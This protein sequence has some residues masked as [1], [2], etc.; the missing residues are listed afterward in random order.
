[1][2]SNIFIKWKFIMNNSII[3][4]EGIALERQ[5]LSPLRGLASVVIDTTGFSV[6]DL[7]R[8]VLSSF[9]RQ[10]ERAAQMSIRVV[11]FGFKYGAPQD[12]DLVF[13]VRFLK[14]PFFVEE[15]RPLSGQDPA[16]ASYVLG[17]PDAVG[18]FAVL[19]PLL[20]YCIPKFRAEGK[21]Y[22][23]IAVGCTG[24]RHRS[25]ALSERIAGQLKE[26]LGVSVEAVHRD[27][28]RA[29]HLSVKGT[30]SGPPPGAAPVPP[31]I[32]QESKNNS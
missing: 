30:P 19:M 28:R 3:V 29:E 18:F 12:A 13:D 20:Q 2:T 6:H 10:G 4:R 25:V 26:D 11:S 1:M 32:L 5:L 15:L 24:G 7:R 14:N 27:T 8:E 23:T 17:D 22:L 9:S 31:A 16:V 21:S